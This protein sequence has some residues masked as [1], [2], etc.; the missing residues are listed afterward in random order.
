MEENFDDDGVAY[1]LIPT[2]DLRALIY[3]A[4]QYIEYPE[5]HNHEPTRN[6]IE[7]AKSLI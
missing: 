1:V 7:S 4:E 3:A 2:K 6:A 5:L